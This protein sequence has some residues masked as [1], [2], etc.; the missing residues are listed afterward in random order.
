MSLESFKYNG[1]E[2]RFWDVTGEV[3]SSSKFSE[4][5]VWS[6]GGGGS[7]GPNGGQI[8]AP[9]IHSKAITN[10]EFW[11]LTADGKE[12]PIQLNDVNIPLK[13]GQKITLIAA[14]DVE[15][16]ENGF[17]SVLINHN[18]DRH[19]SVQNAKSLNES[20]KLEK[21]NIFGLMGIAFLISIT[22]SLVIFDGMFKW[23]HPFEIS[24][25]LMFPVW[26]FLLYLAEKRQK[27][28]IVLLDVHIEK[29]A[30]T[31]Y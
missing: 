3:L 28:V 10:H 2:I 17:I 8:A 19:W 24:A 14:K 21:L 6:S 5:Q 9:T 11:I 27:K 16:A 25:Y 13:E 1:K 18:A 7:V 26:F 30:R 31:L 4:T 20:F 15:D 23:G 29:L 12:K 22:I